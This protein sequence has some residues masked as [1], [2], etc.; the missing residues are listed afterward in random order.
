MVEITISTKNLQ[1]HSAFL[2]NKIRMYRGH[3]KIV[4]RK[5]LKDAK[6]NIFLRPN[7]KV[8]VLIIPLP[9]LSFIPYSK[10]FFA[11]FHKALF[12]SHQCSH[13]LNVKK[14]KICTYPLYFFQHVTEKTHIFLFGLTMIKKPMDLLW[15]S[16]VW[17][18]NYLFLS[19]AL[20][21][22]TPLSIFSM[23]TSS[24]SHFPTME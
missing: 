12:K 7:K 2:I 15:I 20:S 23:L 10:F 3:L 1:N 8:Y 16:N 17:S 4:E 24:N 22:H 21:Q 18:Q 11:I 9:T 13:R 6:E 19:K 14:S 5:H